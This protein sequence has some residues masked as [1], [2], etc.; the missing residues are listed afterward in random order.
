MVTGIL[1][2]CPLCGRS[3]CISPYPRPLPQVARPCDFTYVGEEFDNFLSE[4]GP[5][6]TVPCISNVLS[7]RSKWVLASVVLPF[8]H[9]WSVIYSDT[10][11]FLKPKYCL[12]ISQNKALEKLPTRMSYLKSY[13]PVTVPHAGLTSSDIPSRVLC[14]CLALLNKECSFLN[15]TTVLFLSCSW[16]FS[17]PGIVF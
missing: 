11:T 16:P 10:T 14:V 6:A 9:L 12:F 2:L 3:E 17:G 7:C 15:P 1:L 4:T 8:R 13:H 5:W